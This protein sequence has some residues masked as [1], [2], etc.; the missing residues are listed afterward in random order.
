MKVTY[1]LSYSP[2]YSN[3]TTVKPSFSRG[4]NFAYFAENKNSTKIRTREKLKLAETKGKAINTD[5][6]Y[7]A[8]STRVLDF[9]R[10]CLHACI[11]HT[12]ILPNLLPLLSAE[13][14][15]VLHNYTLLKYFVF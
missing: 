12:Q 14:H 15:V 9:G 8:G 13:I 2:F 4:S 7:S 6:Q 10:H 1:L 11:L 5:S 3:I